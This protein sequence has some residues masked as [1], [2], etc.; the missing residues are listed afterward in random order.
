MSTLKGYTCDSGCELAT[1]G[2][3]A[4][5]RQ[6]F[7]QETAL[8]G[9]MNEKYTFLLGGRATSRWTRIVA[10]WNDFGTQTQRELITS[11]AGM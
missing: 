11:I 8:T 10:G 6:V 2:V 3:C 4:F 9:K 1:T 7:D 5:Q